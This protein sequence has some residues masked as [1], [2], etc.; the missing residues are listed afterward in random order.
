MRDRDVK[1]SRLLWTGGDHLHA[2]ESMLLIKNAESN[3]LVAI[4]G[5]S[6]AA[7]FHD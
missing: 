7:F 5:P 3:L 4:G 2:D 1:K 6:V